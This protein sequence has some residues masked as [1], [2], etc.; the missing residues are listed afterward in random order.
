MKVKFLTILFC[1]SVVAIFINGTTDTLSPCD[2]PVVGGHTGAPGETSCNSCHG[3]TPNSGSAIIDFDLGTTT[4]NP[5][6]TYTGFV[7]LQQ[8]GMQKFG[9]V[10]LALKNSNNTTIGAFNL[11]D[12]VRTRTYADGNRNYVSHTPCG[13]DS[14]DAN[15]WS[16][17]WT[18]PPTNVDTI[19]MY[20]GALAANHDEA[21]TGDYGYKQKIVLAP[22]VS[23]GINEINNNKIKVYPN[24]VADKIVVDGIEGE[25][26]ITVSIIDI[27][28]KTV[29]EK[30]KPASDNPLTVYMSENPMLLQGTYFIK[31]TTNKSTY[32][33]KIITQ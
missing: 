26:L 32:I 18:A 9:F 12:T 20:L 7:R 17:T 25:K 24:P 15:S 22:Q 13:A 27:S 2:S 19:T 16:F 5:G 8:T 29:I 30:M 14:I 10:C 28:G 23:N 3:G 33:K 31:I 1:V 21:T 4:Y 6:Q 11:L